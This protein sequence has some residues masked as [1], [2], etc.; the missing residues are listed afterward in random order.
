MSLPNERDIETALKK[1]SET[2]LSYAQANAF[3]ASAKESIKVAKMENLPDSGTAIEREKTAILSDDYK[4]A[5][6]KYKN[7]VFQNK[8]LE[9]QRETWL[10]TIEVWRSLNANMRRS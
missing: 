2:D 7:A 3:L 1:L 9:L 8:Y 6:K 5:L 10:R 4:E